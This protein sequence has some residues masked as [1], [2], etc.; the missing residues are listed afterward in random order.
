MWSI[1]QMRLQRSGSEGVAEV[2]RSSRNIQSDRLHHIVV[3]R[4]AG[5]IPACIF[6]T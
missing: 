4:L 1:L 2:F 5:D 3:K 6:N